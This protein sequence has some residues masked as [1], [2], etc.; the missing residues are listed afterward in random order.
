M[1]VEPQALITDVEGHGDHVVIFVKLVL[2]LATLLRA[3]VREAEIHVDLLH[4]ATGARH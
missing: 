3:G 2:P 1:S 4:G